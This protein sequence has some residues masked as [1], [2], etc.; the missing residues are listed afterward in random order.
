M[1]SNCPKT[2]PG[3]LRA[4]TRLLFLLAFCLACVTAQPGLAE[5]RPAEWA[6][7]VDLP[8][9]ENFHRV[10]ADLYRA[11]QPGPAAMRAYERFGI[12]TVI[13]LRGFHSDRDEIR[14]TNLILVEIPLKT[15][16][17]GDDKNVVA[18]L[19]AI[20]DAEK[21]VLL[22]CMHGADRTGLMAAMYRMAEQGWSREAAIDEMLNG[23]FGFHT[24]WDNITDYLKTVNVERVRARLR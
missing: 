18:V 12:R 15:W 17:A 22:H 3:A 20:R 24:M 14:G 21:P 10:S 4:L 16:R 9:A 8:G 2:A 11:A 7:P 1:P 5:S 6:Q 13:N 23:G 19:Q